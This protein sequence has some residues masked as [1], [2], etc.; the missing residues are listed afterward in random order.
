[1]KKETVYQAFGKVIKSPEVEDREEL[2]WTLESVAGGSLNPRI[3]EMC[4]LSTLGGGVTNTVSCRHHYN[5]LIL[6]QEY[7]V[8]SY[9]DQ[10]ASILK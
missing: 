5:N 2:L 6:S 7:C 10:N 3:W 4:L 9:M 1:M 8:S